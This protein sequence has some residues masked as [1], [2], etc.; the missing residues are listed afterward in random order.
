[1]ATDTMA[2]PLQGVRVFDAS[3]GVAGPY[4]TWLMAQAGAEVIKIEPAE[5][6]WGRVI[7]LR[8]NGQSSAF[9]TYNSGKKSVTLNLKDDGDLALA[10]RLAASCDVFV[11][12]FRT[13]VIDR[14]GLGYETLS[15]DR[16]DLVYLSVSGFGGRGP[17]AA[18]P[19]MDPIVQAYCGWYDINRGADGAPTQ[20]DH[21][22]IDA[23]TGLYAYQATLAAL[24]KRFRFGA[25]SRL[26][27]S[28]VHAAAAF[29]APRLLDHLLTAGENRRDVGLPW[30]PYQA[31]DGM[32]ALAVRGDPEFRNL[33]EAMGAPELGHDDRFATRKSRSSH[34]TA[35]TAELCRVL[36]TAPAA[37]WED[38][39]R[40]AGIMCARVR[41]V[42]EFMSEA[43][44]AALGLL[45]PFDQ[46]GL[47]EASF[48]AP[49]GFALDPAAMTP[50]PGIGQ[51]TEEVLSAF[52]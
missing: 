39:L 19:A 20:I 8:V 35:L 5:G 13:G 37:E 2:K 48:V 30:G 45:R 41:S 25:G 32:I 10:K 34:A 28:L 43:H 12:S 49:P 24:L 23:L 1:M 21:V 14:L 3:M 15:A 38:R 16:S 7:G 44:V 51:H 17:L 4:A 9:I 52:R 36:A 27:V 46:P 29:L 40:A 31:K 11:E 26:E 6:D 22:P 50:A 33:C 47:G 18:L 42:G